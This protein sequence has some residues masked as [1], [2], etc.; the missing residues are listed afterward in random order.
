MDIPIRI[1]GIAFHVPETVITN[2]D[3][4]KIIDTSDEWIRTR[5]GIERRHVLSGNETAVQMGIKAAEKVLAVSKIN[6][7]EID[8]IIAPA[9]VETHAYPSTACEIQA[10]IGAVNAACF[11]IT[12][13]CS[14]LIYAM[15]IGRALIKSGMAKNILLVATDAVSRCLD[16]TDR[17]SCV[18]FGD[19]AGAMMLTVSQ[20]GQDDILSVDLRADGNCGHFIQMPIPGKNC[21]LVEPNEQEPMFV[22]ME[23]KEVY[24]YVV[25]NLPV[26]IEDCVSKS[27]LKM[28]EIDYL[29]PHQANMRII[30]ALEKRL[31]FNPE[32]VISNI[33]E[34]A[35]TSAASIPIALTEAIQSGKIKLPATAILTGFGAGMTVGTTVV[36]LREGIA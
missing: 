32:N 31:E 24:K 28:S 30:E 15:G 27:G 3:L 29:I 1:A 26:F 25:T 14:G 11:D 18:L 2:D 33:Q 9:S 36:R 7:E 12:A 22:K 17:A 6:V 5:T 23:G 35:N 21:P 4:T 19:G 20:D 13:A 34:Y 8:Y 16:W 10:A